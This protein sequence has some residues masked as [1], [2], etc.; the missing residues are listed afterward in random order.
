M[1]NMR[2]VGGRERARGKMVRAGA[3]PSAGHPRPG[4]APPPWSGR[5][6]LPAP[7]WARA[8]GATGLWRYLS[9]CCGGERGPH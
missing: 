4:A 2:A 6:C 9:P 3:R 8:G 1:A 5:L 7:L